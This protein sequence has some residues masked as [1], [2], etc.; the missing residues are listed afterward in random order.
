MKKILFGFVIGFILTLGINVN[1]AEISGQLVKIFDSST[2]GNVHTFNNNS[3]LNAK[4]GSE[5][6]TADNIGGTLVLY[7]GGEDKIRVAAGTNKPNDAGMINFLDTKNNIR[8][9]IYGDNATFGPMFYL[10]DENGGIA[11][12][13]SLTR[14]TINN[15][16]IITEDY[17]KAN[18]INKSDVQKMIDDAVQKALS[19]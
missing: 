6:G 4:L 13:L 8:A 10:K 11:T 7:N 17:L 19:K 2:G 14:G 15:Q 9:S 3:I 5:A 1:A 12:S 18:Y 16:N